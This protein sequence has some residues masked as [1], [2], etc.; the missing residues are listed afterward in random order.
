MNRREFTIALTAATAGACLVLPGC[1]GFGG[2]EVITLDEAELARQLESRFPIERRVLELLDIRASEP[3][4]HLL[5][6][7][8]QLAFATNVRARD[9]VLGTI[10]RGRVAFDSG[11][12]WDAEDD[13]IRL[14][15]VHVQSLALRESGAAPPPGAAAASAAPRDLGAALAEYLLEGLAIYHLDADRRAKLER[16][17]LRPVAVN[18]TARGVEITLVRAG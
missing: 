1:A 15:R 11:L 14:D 3:T 17:G 5:A 12:R 2:P 10:W 6:D 8:N 16:L 7:R 13:A 9:R 4:V 18:V